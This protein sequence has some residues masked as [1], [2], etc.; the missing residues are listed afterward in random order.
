MEKAATPEPTASRKE[1]PIPL[2]EWR[3]AEASL[4]AGSGLT[5]LLIEGPQP[6]QLSVSNNNSVCHALQSS[7]AHAHLCDQ[8]AGSMHRPIAL[9]ADISRPECK[10]IDRSAE[11]LRVN[12]HPILFPPK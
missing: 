8:P 5:L 2:P 12:H 6:P 3:K 7:P 9:L 11:A 4:A 10:K 1:E